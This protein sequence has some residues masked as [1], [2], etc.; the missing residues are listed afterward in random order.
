M[1]LFSSL[2]QLFVGAPKQPPATAPNPAPRTNTVTS[3]VPKVSKPVVMAASTDVSFVKLDRDATEIAPGLRCDF[4][5]AERSKLTR[6]PEDIEVTRRIELSFSESLAE[7]PAGLRTGS[8]N[9]A[10]CKAL[11]R[12]P[13]GLEVTFLDLTQ[14]PNLTSLPADLRLRGGA[15]A[16]KDCT[17][18]TALPEGLGEVAWLDLR[19]CTGITA[20]PQGLV[21]TSSMD[22]TGSGITEIPESYSHVGLRSNGVPVTQLAA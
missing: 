5:S 8:L 17:G 20:L 22:L 15:L 4:L 18:L 16:L 7:L 19:G 3:G 10:Q 2:K 11:E 12:L 1:S 9:L 21:V 13:S 14:C 6:L